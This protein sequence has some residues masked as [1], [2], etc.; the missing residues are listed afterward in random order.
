[1]TGKA[2]RPLTVRI[3]A[4]RQTEY[5]DLSEKYENYLPR[6]CGVA[7]GTVFFSYGG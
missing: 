1:M 6:P 4:L 7:P 5:P 3:T 2:A